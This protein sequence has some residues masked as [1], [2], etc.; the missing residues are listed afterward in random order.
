MAREDMFAFSKIVLFCGGPTMD[1]MYPISKYIY[2]SAAEK[3]MTAYYPKEFEDNIKT[4]RVLKKYFTENENDGLVFRSLLNK[5]R[6][7]EFRKKKLKKFEDRILAIPLTNDEVMPPESVK[8]TLNA[9]GLKVK[10]EEMHFPFEYNHISPFPLNEKIKNETN[11]CFEQV[12]SAVAD[13]LE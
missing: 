3:V 8:K 5:N 13:W 2:D 6:F 4:D 10:I 7:S 9:D 11:E 1:M 12:F